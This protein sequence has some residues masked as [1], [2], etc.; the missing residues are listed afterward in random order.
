MAR[1]AAPLQVQAV[2]A[3]DARR[4]AAVDTVGVALVRTVPASFAARLCRGC[5]P[6]GRRHIKRCAARAGAMHGLR[7][8]RGNAPASELG[9]KCWI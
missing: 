2:P 8:E 5:D 3:G 4:F 1:F 9:R 7:T 6:M